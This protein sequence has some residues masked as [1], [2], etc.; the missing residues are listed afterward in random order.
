MLDGIVVDFRHYLHHSFSMIVASLQTLL[1]DYMPYEPFESFEERRRT[2][3]AHML[4]A[5]QRLPIQVILLGLRVV[6]VGGYS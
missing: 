6:E 1:L 3:F 5:R 4:D 2:L